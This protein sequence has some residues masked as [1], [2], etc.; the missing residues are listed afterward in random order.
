MSASTP[1][2][3]VTL[4]K[5]EAHKPGTVEYLALLLLADTDTS[6]MEGIHKY[7]TLLQESNLVPKD[8]RKHQYVVGAM[9][10][11]LNNYEE[12]ENGAARYAD[13]KV[14]RDMM[15]F[16]MLINNTEKYP[17]LNAFILGWQKD[18]EKKEGE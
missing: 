8:L 13:A 1:P 11:I 7:I 12:S 16:W 15:N 17:G 4:G 5:L 6:V 3:V 10:Y 2:Q 9:E 18:Q 14:A